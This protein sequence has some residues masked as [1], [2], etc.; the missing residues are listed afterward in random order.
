MLL[1]SIYRHGNSSD[2]HASDVRWNSPINTSSTAIRNYCK[3]IATSHCTEVFKL[4]IYRWIAH[5]T[6]TPPPGTH[7]YISVQ[8]DKNKGH[9]TYVP[10]SQLLDKSF[11]LLSDLF[12]PP[13]PPLHGPLTLGPRRFGQFTGVSIN[14]S[15]RSEQIPRSLRS[16]GKL[17]LSLTVK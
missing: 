15:R 14:K 8:L 12:L 9:K 13:L 16:C 11:S 7:F 6:L 2:R 4:N 17:G 3:Q 1:L 10:L 5:T